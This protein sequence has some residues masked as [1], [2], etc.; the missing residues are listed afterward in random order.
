MNIAEKFIGVHDLK[1]MKIQHKYYGNNIWEIHRTVRNY[2]EELRIITDDTVV[3]K[4]NKIKSFDHRVIQQVHDLLAAVYRYEEKAFNT[5]TLRDFDVQLNFSAWLNKW[6]KSNPSIIKEI[7]ILFTFENMERGYKAEHKAQLIVFRKNRHI[8]WS[9]STLEL[10]NDFNSKIENLLEKCE[11]N[12]WVFVGLIL[13]VL[14]IFLGLYFNLKFIS[15]KLFII[16]ICLLIG[17]INLFDTGIFLKKLNKAFKI[18]SILMLSISI[19]LLISSFV[20]VSDEPCFANRY[21]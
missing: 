16:P 8:P 15:E 12:I 4:F 17:F 9:K 11:E 5:K 10:Y 18:S 1:T 2:Q 6:I 7:I 13:S 19:F 3:E 14:P 21:C 20:Y